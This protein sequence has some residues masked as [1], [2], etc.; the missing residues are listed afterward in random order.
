MLAKEQITSHCQALLEATRDYLDRHNE[1]RYIGHDETTLTERQI[2]E[3]IRYRMHL[4]RLPDSPMRANGLPPAPSFCKHAQ[5][6]TNLFLADFF[7][8]AADTAA[9]A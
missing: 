1:E 6:L 8:R 2:H 7:Q 4:R 5:M 9:R 3:L